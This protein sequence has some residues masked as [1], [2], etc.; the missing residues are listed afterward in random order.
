M[1]NEVVYDKAATDNLGPDGNH[2]APTIGRHQI[3]QLIRMQWTEYQRKRRVRWQFLCYALNETFTVPDDFLVGELV[4]DTVVMQR[5]I[6]EDGSGIYL[7]SQCNP[8][9]QVRIDQG[10]EV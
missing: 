10:L 7:G 8:R 6:P 3:K 4:V 2:T 1:E 9:I 5:L